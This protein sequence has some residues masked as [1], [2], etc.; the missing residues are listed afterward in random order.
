MFVLLVFPSLFRYAKKVCNHLRVSPIVKAYILADTLL[1]SAWSLTTPIFA[2]FVVTRIS[3]GN[4]EVAATG[5]SIYLISRV[6]FELL[7]ARY[8]SK[9]SD[10]AKF[11]ITVTGMFCMSSAYM[12]FAFSHTVF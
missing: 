10:R 6:I 12:G 4:I 2:I 5:Y 7:S 11:K 3:G 8:L 9:K 1:W